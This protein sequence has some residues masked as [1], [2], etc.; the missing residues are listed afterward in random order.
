MEDTMGGYESL[1]WIRD[2]KGKEYVCPIDA[3]KG[4]TSD[5]IELSNEE[6]EVCMD[7]NLLI[8][9]ERW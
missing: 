2:K 3:L 1:A 7:V 9:T 4:D 5:R 8:G 6:R